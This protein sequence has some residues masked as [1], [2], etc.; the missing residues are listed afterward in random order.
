MPEERDHDRVSIVMPAY[1]LGEAIADN[2]EQVLKALASLDDVEIIVSDDGS[3]DATFAEA[4]KGAA[5]NDRVTVVRSNV[6][7]GKGAAFREGFSVST[8]ELIVLLDGDLDLPPDQLPD[9]I[10]SFPQQNVDVLVGEKLATASTGSYPA[11]RRILSSIFSFV[12]RILFRLPVAE[13]QTGLKLFTRA[14]LDDTLPHLHITR[15]SFDL[16]LLVRIQRA[17]FSIGSVPVE[18]GEKGTG[19]GLQ[20]A[21]LWEMGRDTVRIWWWSVRG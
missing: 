11:P 20:L 18:L 17:G 7:Q 13:T 15:Y 5:A 4:D 8:G 12:A 14:S 6:N 9:L 1:Q 16:E 19:S 21:T 10:A 3:T 2:V